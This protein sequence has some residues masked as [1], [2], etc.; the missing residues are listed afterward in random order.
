MALS[1][2]LPFY[3]N[4]L[5]ASVGRDFVIQRVFPYL[6]FLPQILGGVGALDG[7]EVQVA[8]AVVFSDR[9]V[10]RVRE[11]AGALVAEPRHVVFV[12][13]VRVGGVKT[14]GGL[15]SGSETKDP[16]ERLLRRIK[17][18]RR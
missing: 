10:S 4:Q 15:Q 1:A 2:D 9:G 7:L 6:D 5:V 3:C 8:H 17:R 18:R 16:N 13:V 12:P 14:N 11:G